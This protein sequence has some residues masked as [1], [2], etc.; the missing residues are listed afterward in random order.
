MKDMEFRSRLVEEVGK[1]WALARSLEN[2]LVH[3]DPKDEDSA[4][5][6]DSAMSIAYLLSDT[7]GL[8][9]KYV[10]EA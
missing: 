8:L 2:E 4:E 10:Y 6:L 1:V 3:V 9:R 5:S 7:A